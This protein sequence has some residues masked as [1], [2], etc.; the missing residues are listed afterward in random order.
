MTVES[1]RKDLQV[2]IRW[3]QS[4]DLLSTRKAGRPSHS[5]AL[6]VQSTEKESV[7]ETQQ[8]LEKA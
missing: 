6:K 1:S 5:G 3:E 7:L 8:W 4:L 2:L